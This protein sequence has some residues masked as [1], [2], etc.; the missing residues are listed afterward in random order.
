[1]TTQQSFEKFQKDLKEGNVGEQIIAYFLKNRY[2]YNIQSFNNDKLYDFIL[3]KDGKLVKFE[4][5][6]DCYEHFKGYNTNNIFFEIQHK[7]KP[8]GV[9]ATTAEWFVYYFPFHEKVYFIKT[10][11]VKKIMKERP[12]LFV[13]KEMSGDGG[14]VLG[15]TMDRFDGEEYF[16]IL[17]LKLPKY[18]HK[19][20]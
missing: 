15:F 20:L 8:S 13:R 17:D 19:Y 5:K 9:M 1:M 6:T 7:G 3:E 18:F 12:D 11:D 16:K 4:V 10:K 2:G 14:R